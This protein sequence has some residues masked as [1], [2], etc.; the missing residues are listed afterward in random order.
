MHRKSQHRIKCVVSK[1]CTSH[2][3]ELTLDCQVKHLLFP[4]A[5][6]FLKNSG[7]L[8]YY[9]SG[10]SEAYDINLHIEENV[11]KLKLDGDVALLTRTYENII[12]NSIRHNESCQIEIVLSQ[13]ERELLIHFTDNGTGMPDMVIEGLSEEKGRK[14]DGRIRWNGTL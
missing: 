7:L 11:E 12:G 1:D 9:N 3:E 5:V 6:S 8:S 10:L 14:S 2:P 13:Q 4:D